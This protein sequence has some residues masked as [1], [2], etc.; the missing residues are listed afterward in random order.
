VTAPRWAELCRQYEA[1]D[2]RVTGPAGAL[3]VRIGTP[4]P[5]LDALLAEERAATGVFITA[6]NP[7]SRQRSAIENAAANRR[8]AA[9]LE[10][11]GLR[12]LPHEGI[13]DGGDW[14]ERGF[15]VLDLGREEGQLLARDF[16]Q[17]A[18]VFCARGQAPA[19]VSTGLADEAD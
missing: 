1:T 12:H 14:T 4:S 9:R 19:L 18:I 2:Y 5:A 17:N 8:L 15:L 6:D 10:E 11:A 13:G 7:R 3:A 16:G